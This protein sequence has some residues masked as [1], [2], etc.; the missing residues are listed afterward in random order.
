M[1]KFIFTLDN[2]SYYLV[3]NSKEDIQFI[4]PHKLPNANIEQN[5]L[6]ATNDI[7]IKLFVQTK[8]DTPNLIFVGSDKDVKI[9][10]NGS[11][12]LIPNS[13]LAITFT[14]IDGGRNWLVNSCSAAAST[15]E[16]A[17]KVAK[18]AQ[19]VAISAQTVAEES[20]G[21]AQQTTDKINKVSTELQKL[22]TNIEDQNQ[23]NET[24]FENLNQNITTHTQ[25]INDI[26]DS[27]DFVNNQV[28]SLTQDIAEID[29]SLSTLNVTTEAIRV[30]ADGAFQLQ[31]EGY[32][33]IDSGVTIANGKKIL[34][35]RHKGSTPVGMFM[36]YYP[37]LTDKAT[38]EG[39]E[40][41]EIGS[42]TNIL[43][44]N[45][46]GATFT[47]KDNIE[48]TVDGHIRVDYREKIGSSV[49]KDQLAYMSDIKKILENQK[50]IIEHIKNIEN[51]VF[52]IENM[53]PTRPFVDPDTLPQ[54]PNL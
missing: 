10:T 30:K 17:E 5:V 29:N 1:K 46:C 22:N 25:A 43:C 7:N 48:S 11:L 27:V 39:L 16:G 47:D 51:S 14:T 8:L 37:E 12:E 28:T 53:T 45:H 13:M 33:K 20:L 9:I 38:N 42:P 50:I 36:S 31:N 44:L 23:I 41:T 19:E 32:Q 54:L 4:L 35:E 26:A 52:W 6:N 34:L 15:A 24:K 2:L 49:V 21:I 3:I 40:Q 18:N